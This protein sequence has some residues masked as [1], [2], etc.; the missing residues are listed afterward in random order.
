MTEYGLEPAFV[1]LDYATVFGAHT[2]LI[3]TTDWIPTNLSGVMGSYL[4]HTG[5]PVDAEAMID[6]LCAAMAYIHKDDTTI[7]QATIF[8]KADE[9][10]PAIPR[11]S[12]ALAVAGTSG[13]TTHAKAIQKTMN[14]RSAGIQAA[15]LVF[16]DVPH[17]ALDFNKEYP[18]DWTADDLA[19]FG[20]LSLATNAW[21][22]RDNTVITSPV[23][24]TWNLN[25]QLRK[26]YKMA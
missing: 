6:D 22:A 13:L 25:Q 2:H 8:T 18:I 1:K 7:T 24:I 4:G 19:L 10:S 5:L 21:T 12:K 16:L 14:F 23:S 15:K 11:A 20:E 26:Q 17:S 9:D 3:C